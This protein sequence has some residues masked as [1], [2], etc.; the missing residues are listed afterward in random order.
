MRVIAE[1][2]KPEEYELDLTIRM[3]VKEWDQIAKALPDTHPG[4]T[5]TQQIRDVLQKVKKQFWADPEV[6]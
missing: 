2:V 3:T 6:K 4:W 1:F 5:L